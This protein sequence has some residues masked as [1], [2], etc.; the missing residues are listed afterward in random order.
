M[1]YF[2]VP[3][4]LI[5]AFF[6]GWFILWVLF[7]AVMSLKRAKDEGL[8]VSGTTSYSLA[9]IVLGIGYFIDFLVNITLAVVLFFEPPFEMTVTKRCEKHLHETGYR[10]KVARWLCH[11]LLDPFQ[12][13]GHCH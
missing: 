5:L 11:N 7:L 12:I 8:L 13:G 2:I 4:Q 1:K 10:G 3:F 9:L 6:T